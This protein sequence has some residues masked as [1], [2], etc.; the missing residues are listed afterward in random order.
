MTCLILYLKNGQRFVF[1]LFKF[2]KYLCCDTSLITNYKEEINPLR[3]GELHS[4]NDNICLYTCTNSYVL[5]YF[6]IDEDSIEDLGDQ[7]R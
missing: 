6:Q 2:A 4:F 1:I 7:K 3:I 5:S